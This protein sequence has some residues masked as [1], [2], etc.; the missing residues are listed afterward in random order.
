MP[1][2]G[3]NNA[4]AVEIYC[5]IC[6]SYLRQAHYAEYDAADACCKLEAPAVV[7][8][9]FSVQLSQQLSSFRAIGTACRGQRE[10]PCP[11]FQP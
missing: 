5:G 3:A 1:Y 2:C 11:L 8:I 7:F 10:T 4:E 9:F 6:G